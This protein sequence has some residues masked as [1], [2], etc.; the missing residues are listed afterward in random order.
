M[1]QKHRDIVD[2]DGI[3]REGETGDQCCG[4]HEREGGQKV[5]G[6]FLAVRRFG[7]GGECGQ[8]DIGGAERCDEG[9]FG[10]GADDVTII[11]VHDG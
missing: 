6:D 8:F 2:D 1:G 11:V 9:C 4:H 5:R 3:D 10:F 7:L